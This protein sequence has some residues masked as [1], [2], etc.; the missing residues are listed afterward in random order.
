MFKYWI[1]SFIIPA[2]ILASFIIS[3]NWSFTW[4]PKTEK[5]Q[6]KLTLQNK[7]NAS[8]FEIRGGHFCSFRNG[9]K[10]IVLNTE[11]LS[12]QKQSTGYFRFSLLEEIRIKNAFIEL[13]DSATDSNRMVNSSDTATK[14][15]SFTNSSETATESSSFNGV[16]SKDFLRFFPIKRAISI[17]IEPVHIELHKNNSV[18]SRISSETS[19]I[20]VKQGD[21]HLKGNVRIISRDKTL[22]ADSISFNPDNSTFSTDQYFTLETPHKNWK[23]KGLVTDIY[24]QSSSLQ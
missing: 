15:S 18:V 9:K 16:F 24:L 10:I 6:R 2:I 22:T 13:Y 8:V 21:I 1:F 12:I 23:G 3:L 7:K 19:E 17:R 4:V 20:R 11:K 14:A 5:I